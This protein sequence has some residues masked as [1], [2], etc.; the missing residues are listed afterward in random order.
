MNI[1]PIQ[2]KTFF[3]ALAI[4]LIITGCSEAT[5]HAPILVDAVELNSDST[6]TGLG[7]TYKVY[8]KAAHG[9]NPVFYTDVPYNSGERLVPM[10]RLQHIVDERTDAYM[11]TIAVKDRR[12]EKLE[13]D[14]DK[15]ED[16]KYAME[17]HLNEK[18]TLIRFL[19]GK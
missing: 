3:F 7:G 9:C 1:Y 12:I 6:H 14:I 5:L 11:D 4:S 18:T 13:D 15:L 10:S 8:L 17:R 19:T 16:E 2:M